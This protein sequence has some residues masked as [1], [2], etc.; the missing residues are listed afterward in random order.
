LCN[1]CL[2]FTL[3]E[4]KYLFGFSCEC[5]KEED[6][7]CVC[8]HPIVENKSLTNV[9]GYAYDLRE[10]RRR[11]KEN[12]RETCAC[13]RGSLALSLRLSF[14]CHSLARLRPLSLPPRVCARVRAVCVYLCERK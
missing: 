14:M 11:E 13:V 9:E 7:V 10:K 8:E 4:D 6:D 2:F 3:A 1:E 5:E 12:V